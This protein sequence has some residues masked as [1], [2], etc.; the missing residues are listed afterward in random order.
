MCTQKGGGKEL[1]SACVCTPLGGR[2][3]RRYADDYGDG[4]DDDDDDD[5]HG[6]DDEC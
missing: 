3:R 1:D 2:A 6:S 4:D 5:D